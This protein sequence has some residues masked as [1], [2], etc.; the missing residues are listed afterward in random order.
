[1]SLP[2]IDGPLPVTSSEWNK[3]TW[4]IARLYSLHSEPSTIERSHS[5]HC[6]HSG[7]VL[8][9]DLSTHWVKQVVFWFAILVSK[10]KDGDEDWARAKDGGW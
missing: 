8:S 7:R 10:T 6:L 9:L 3:L 5:Y 4:S 1:M 2:G